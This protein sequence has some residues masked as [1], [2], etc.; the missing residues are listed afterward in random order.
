MRG[1]DARAASY[2]CQPLR[3]ER[4]SCRAA[5]CVPT[6]R[7]L[8]C[9]KCTPAASATHPTHMHL[10]AGPGPGMHFFLMILP[11]PLGFALCWQPNCLH[12]PTHLEVR[13]KALP[14]LRGHPHAHK[15]VHAVLQHPVDGS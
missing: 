5:V 1:G 15:P 2:F 10:V 12:T 9:A 13:V 6:L 11:G 4:R 7:L 14:K 3:D 8:V